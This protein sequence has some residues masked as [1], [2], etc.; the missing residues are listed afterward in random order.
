MKSRRMPGWLLNRVVMATLIVGLGCS[1]LW[2]LSVIATEG[3]YFFQE[4]STP[5]LVT[6]IVLLS[7]VLVF[8]LVNFAVL[9]KKQRRKSE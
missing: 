1:Q 7:L 5:M 4:P 8:G 2:L 9:F 3:K 6:E